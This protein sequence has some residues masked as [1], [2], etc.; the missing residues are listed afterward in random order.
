MMSEIEKA[1]CLSGACALWS[2]WPGYLE[3]PDQKRLLNF[4][5]RHSIPIVTHHASGH[6]YLP[7]LQRLAT[8][9]APRRLVPIHSFAPGRFGESFEN[10]EMHPDG[11]CWDV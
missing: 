6:A 8:A 3:Q 4:F 5:E 1:G 11:E 9:M 10:V 2:M 7:D